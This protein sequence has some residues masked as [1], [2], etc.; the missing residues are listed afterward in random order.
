MGRGGNSEEIVGAAPRRAR[1]FPDWLLE[2]DD[3]LH[4]EL[5]PDALADLAAIAEDLFP[6]DEL[7]GDVD[8]NW[9]G[10]VSKYA[11]RHLLADEVD[12]SKKVGGFGPEGRYHCWVVLHDGTIVDPT[13]LQFSDPRFGDDASS[14]F[15][16]FPGT[17]TVAVV[18]PVHPFHRH[19][20][21]RT[22]TT[23]HD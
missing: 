21:A 17:D 16:D 12:C 13:I 20:G 1:G 9:C 6:H 19:Y 5:S 18:P 22:P 11:T 15:A 4:P 7:E 2:D 10:E 8:H 3:W 14:D 23:P